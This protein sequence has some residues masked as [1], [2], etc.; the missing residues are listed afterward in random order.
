MTAFQVKVFYGEDLQRCGTFFINFTEYHDWSMKRFI[1]RIKEVSK[2]FEHVSP[3]QIRIRYLDDENCYVNLEEE[4]MKEMFRCARSV[5]G[6]DWKR[7]SVK[8]A[9][10]NSP[11]PKPSKR[12]RQEFHQADSP[13]PRY[14]SDNERRHDVNRKRE[15]E[16]RY[17]TPTERLIKSKENEIKK[18]E[19]LITDKKDSLDLIEESFTAKTFDNSRPACSKCHLRSGHVRTN[20]T[21]EQCT[22]ARYCGDLKRHPED[23]KEVK[24]LKSALSFHETQLRKM[25]DELHNLQENIKSTKRSY[26]QQIHS[27]LVNSDKAKYMSPDGILDWMALNTD[28]KKLEKIFSGKL[29]GPNEDLQAAIAKHDL[30]EN[31]C[32]PVPSALSTTVKELWTKKGLKFPGSGPIYVPVEKNSDIPQPNN[33]E[34]ESYQV[35]LAIRESQRGQNDSRDIAG[36][37]GK[38][39][40]SRPAPTNVV[41]NEYMYSALSSPYNYPYFPSVTSNFPNFHASGPTPAPPT[42]FPAATKNSFQYGVN[43]DYG[44]EYSHTPTSGRSFPTQNNIPEETS[45]KILSLLW[46]TQQVSYQGVPSEYVSLA[47]YKY[48]VL[49][50][51]ILC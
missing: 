15:I 29:P 46:R 17:L 10:W 31:A 45:Q 16:D 14:V 50:I 34:E 49:V 44:F 6:V 21:N 41:R 30:Q 13:S 33:P 36:G 28:S 18:Q 37:D 35:E 22:S 47:Y 2:A 5:D 11:V 3:D 24:E 32:A 1:M 8:A 26:S 48:Y 4:L 25:Q 9:I 19:Q 43:A 40:T 42:Y 20:C 12:S 51:I 27:N 38:K 7:I 39:A 23:K